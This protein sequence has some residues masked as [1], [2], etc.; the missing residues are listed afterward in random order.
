MTIK[1]KGCG[2]TF[3]SNRAF[4]AHSPKC[5]GGGMHK[6]L[7]EMSL[8]ELMAHLASRKGKDF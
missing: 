2:A 4:E 1:C 3:K 6:P 5:T 7:G 8:E